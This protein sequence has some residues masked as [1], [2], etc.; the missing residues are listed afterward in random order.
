M[1]TVGTLFSGIGVPDLACALLGMDVLF[2][3]EIDEFCQKVLAKHE[4]RYWPNVR[5]FTDVRSVG[6]GNLPRVDILIGGFPCQDLSF[7]G[8]RKGMGEGTRSG[9]W[10]AFARIIGE[11]QP[12]IVVIENVP[13]ILAAVRQTRRVHPARKHANIYVSNR[14]RQAPPPVLKVLHQLSEMGYRFSA[15]C[16]SAGELG[17]QHKR[18]RWWCVAYRENSGVNRGQ[19]IETDHAERRDTGKPR[20]TG[21]NGGIEITRAAG[22]AHASGTRWTQQH[23][24]AVATE[25]GYI[26]GEC[27]QMGNA[28]GIGRETGRNLRQ[29]RHI[30]HRAKRE[31][32]ETN[33]DRQQRTVRVGTR[34]GAGNT[35]Y[36]AR[37]NT[38]AQSRMGGNA[39]GFARGLDFVRRVATPNQA[40]FDYE[41]PRVVT[42]GLPNRANRIKALGNAWDFRN[43]YALMWW[44]KDFLDS[45]GMK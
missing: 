22:V 31:N 23:V 30:L 38:A 4:K 32:Q 28:T 5:R 1:Y 43:A 29:E 14:Q 16:I 8:R 40:Q 36:S 45:E 34:R 41:P 18:E 20:G 42:K 7:A 10:S 3:V 19:R 24:T 11:L 21:S 15:G 6:I 37:H 9:L 39:D 27:S 12:R 2:Q 25:P 26:A 13:G 17:A 33:T 44:V 35:R